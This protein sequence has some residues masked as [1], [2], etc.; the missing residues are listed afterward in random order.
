MTPFDKLVE[1]IVEDGIKAARNDYSKPEDKLRLEGSIKGFEECLGKNTAELAELLGSAR[2]K[3]M[4]KFD[5][6]AEDYWY[7]RSREGEIE[8]VCN[9]VSAALV[10]LG[11]T[12]IVSPTGAGYR[13]LM[14]LANKDQG[15]LV[16]ERG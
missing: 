5:E 10:A 2:K 14:E 15:L 16:V 3:V 4:E 7:W 6:Q 12:V 9:V 1:D 11:L 8:W 13:K